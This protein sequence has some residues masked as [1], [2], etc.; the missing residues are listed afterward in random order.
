MCVLCLGVT[1]C[2]NCGR[3]RYDGIGV[4]LNVKIERS[5]CVW[6]ME[7]LNQVLYK[8]DGSMEY[9]PKMAE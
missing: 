8:R 6:E 2:V 1:A 7:K 4:K 3:V 5:V 9:A